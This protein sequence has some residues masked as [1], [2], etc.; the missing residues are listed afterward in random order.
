M[1]QNSPATSE[2]LRGKSGEIRG[3]N[4]EI[5]GQEAVKESVLTEAS[6]AREG[7]RF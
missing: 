1:T 7:P 3:G 6:E 5:R 2:V 4:P